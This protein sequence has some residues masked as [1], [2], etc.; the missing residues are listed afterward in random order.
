LIP[1]FFNYSGHALTVDTER[2]AVWRA[3]TGFIGRVAA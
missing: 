2:E 1:H 3:V